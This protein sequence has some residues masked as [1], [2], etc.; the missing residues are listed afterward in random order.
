MFI[1]LA[2]FQ[3]IW[4]FWVYECTCLRIYIYIYLVV[5]T[6]V[7]HNPRVPS[8]FPGFFLE[9]YI[10]GM[11][12]ESFFE[13][14]MQTHPSMLEYASAGPCTLHPMRFPE[15]MFFFW[16]VSIYLSFLIF[17]I[18]TVHTPTDWNFEFYASFLRVV[19]RQF[20]CSMMPHPSFQY[21][22]IYLNLNTLGQDS[23]CLVA[24]RG[25]AAF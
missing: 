5:Q 15:A 23:N 8:V 14:M 22:F 12:I 11:Y 16:H 19:Y 21:I 20:E 24:V 18:C 13:N 3:G 17:N 25:C 10:L 7:P 2:I 1:V 4:R 6:I 9:T